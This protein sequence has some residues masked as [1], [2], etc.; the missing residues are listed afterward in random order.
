MPSFGLTA[1]ITELMM[2]TKERA[3]E[4]FDKGDINLDEFMEFVDYAKEDFKQEQQ[5]SIERGEWDGVAGIG[6][7]WEWFSTKDSNLS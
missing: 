7:W 4:I 6:D 1:R 2:T 3:R 5:A